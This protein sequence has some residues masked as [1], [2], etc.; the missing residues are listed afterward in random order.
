MVDNGDGVGDRTKEADD[1]GAGEDVAATGTDFLT[2]FQGGLEAL[3]DNGEGVGDADEGVGDGTEEAQAGWFA[4]TTGDSGFAG[5]DEEYPDGAGTGE[6]IAAAGTNLFAGFG[7]ALQG[8]VDGEEAEEL[9]I[10]PSDGQA[11][12]QQSFLE[13]YGNLDAWNAAT[14]AAA[15]PSTGFFG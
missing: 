3:V 7:G 14:P 4:Q 9:R 8:F 15:A 10:D 6:E 1:A 12:N 13:V 5:G 11:Y 2:G